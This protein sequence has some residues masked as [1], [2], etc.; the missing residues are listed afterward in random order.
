MDMQL[1]MPTR[2]TD[3]LFESPAAEY[4]TLTERRERVF[5]LICEFQRAVGRP[6]G[7]NEAIGILQAI[8]PSSRAYFSAVETLLDKIT[9][10]GAAPHRGEHRSILAELKATLD[11]CTAPGAKP[12]AAA[13]LAHALDALVIHEA[14]IRLRGSPELASSRR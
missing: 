13:D 11:Q 9:A 2:Y 5:A 3:V 14:T 10:A 12:I 4:T 7:L 6:Q 8:L 1:V